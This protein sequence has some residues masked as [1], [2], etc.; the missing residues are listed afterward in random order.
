LTERVEAKLKEIFETD[1]AAFLVA[2]GTAANALSLSLLTP[3]WGAIYCHQDAHIAVDECGAPE[4]YTGGAK[5]VDL[6][7]DMAS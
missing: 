7:G 6:A 3:S 4:F 5:L 2:T 1:L